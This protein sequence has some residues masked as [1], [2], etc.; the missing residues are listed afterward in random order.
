MTRVLF[1]GRAYEL[2]AGES[3]LDGL[4]RGGAD[5]TFSC[6][7][8]TC[9]S[10]MLKA[11]RG[12]PG[13]AS[14]RGLRPSLVEHGYFLPCCSVPEERLWVA[15]PDSADLTT[16]LVLAERSELAPGVVR[17]L[18]EPETNVQ[19]RA[20][21]FANLVHPTSGASRSYSLA[22]IAECDYFLEFHV[23][24]IEGG[25]LSPWL[26]SELAVGDGLVM[27]GPMGRCTYD[28]SAP[29]ASLVL[30][31]TGT[32]LAPLIGVARDAL[33]MHGH[34]GP[35][36]LVHCAADAAGLYADEV[37]RGL[38]DAYANFTYVGVADGRDVVDVAFEHGDDFEGTRM[39]VAGHP[40]MV[41]QA[42]IRAVSLGVRRADIL[43]DPFDSPVPYTPDDAAT[44]RSIEPDP[45]LW[46]ALDHGKGLSAILQDFYGQAFEDERLAPF[47]HHVTKRRAIEKQ[48]AFLRLIITGGGQFLGMSPFN[49]HHWMVISD[50]LFDY[51]EALLDACMERWGLPK[52]MM[53][54]WAALHERY[55]RA[56][57][58]NAPRGLLVDGV[59]VSKT[60]W[61]EETIEIATVCDGCCTEML[62]GTTGRLDK[63]TGQ[64]FCAA[65]ASRDLR[66]SDALPVVD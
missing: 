43:A 21:Q 2:D 37:L 30:V 41:E 9:H 36:R 51:R 53:R 5:V 58:K 10:C 4:V 7:R 47:F 34:T 29:D 59:E 64:L 32:G 14:R 3:V 63:R 35:I 22:S 15:R 48:Y 13:D 65:C 11:E 54:R 24:V 66:L 52:P 17:L 46:A 25:A 16:R 20:G 45:D 31:A 33:Q 18:F 39:H 44:L 19:W 27:Q 49:A 62:P 1:D 55:R 61:T 56:I 40:D 12:D 42:R 50:E 6:R 57:V 38:D 26:A 23:K 28:T 60:G 8:G